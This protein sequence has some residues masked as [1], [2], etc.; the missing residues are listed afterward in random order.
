[1]V[2][3]RKMSEEYGEVF[4]I[5][6]NEH[7]SVGRVFNVF[8][9]SVRDSS[10][11][12]TVV[13]CVCYFREIARSRSYGNSPRNSGKNLLKGPRRF[14]NGEAVEPKCDCW[15]GNYQWRTRSGGGRGGTFENAL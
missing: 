7:Y 8:Y 5:L 1:M 12:I 14:S 9:G 4:E 10:E 3:T 13:E 6:V 15:V 11:Q 2:I